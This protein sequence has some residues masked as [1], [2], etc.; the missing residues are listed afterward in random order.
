M[1][2]QARFLGGSAA[3]ASSPRVA[4]QSGQDSASLRVKYS[5]T[6][7]LDGPVTG[8]SPA[9]RTCRVSSSVLRTSS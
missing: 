7:R 3:R 9:R 8:F 2:D 1:R 6:W 5:S 4:P